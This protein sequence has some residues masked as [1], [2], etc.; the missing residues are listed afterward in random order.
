MRPY[1]QFNKGIDARRS[2][3]ALRRAEPGR[4]GRLGVRSLAARVLTAVLLAV[5]AALLALPAQAQGLTTFVSNTQ[6]VSEPRTAS[7]ITAQSFETGANPDGYTIS[8]IQLKLHSTSNPSALTSAK[9]REYNASD[10]P[11]DLVATLTNPGTLVSDSLNTFTAPAGTTLDAN[12]TY[13][14]MLNEGISSSN[15]VIFATTLS[16]EE[17]G[18]TDW[19]IGNGRLNFTTST[20]DWNTSMFSLLIEIRGTAGTLINTPATGEPAITGAAELGQTLSAATTGISDDEGTTKADAGDAG[21]AYTYQWERV[22]ADGSSNPVDIQGATDSTYTVISADV[23][24]AIRVKVNF[25]DDVGFDEGPLASNALPAGGTVTCDGV[26]CA[27]LYVQSIEGGGKG[28]AN[29]STGDACMNAAHLSEDEFNHALTD[30]RVTSVQVKSNGQLQLWMNPDIVAGS[31]TL[32]LHVGSDTFAFQNADEE[33][34]NN[35]F[36]N[37]SGLTWANG[38]AVELKLTEGPSTDAT[39]SGLALEGATGGETIDLTPVFDAGTITYTASVVNGIDAVK[40]R[41]TANDSNAM[42]VITNDDDTS[43]PD[44]AELSLNVGSNTLTLTV[45]AEDGNTTLTYTI[46]VTRAV[47]P[48]LVVSVPTLTVDEAGS[49]TFTV[50]LATQ[51]S[52]SVTVGVTSDDTGAATASPA[53]LTFTTAD[54]NTT[55]TVTVSGVD[56]SDT[57]NES[58]TVTAS[59]SGG[60]Y[61]GKTGSVSVSVTDDDTANLVLNLTSLTVDE[62]GS[63]TFTVKLATQP[64][65]SVTVGVTSDDTGAATASPASLTFTTG[66]WNTTKTVTVSGVDDSDTDNESLTVTASASGGGYAGKTGSVSVSVTDDDTANLVLNLTSLTVDEAGSGT[67]TVKLATQ[68]S[69]SVTVGVTSDDTGAA[70]ASPASLTFTMSDWDTTQTVTV[71]GV[72]DSDAAAESVMVSLSASGGGYAGKIGSVSVSVTDNDTANLV[73]TPSSLTVGETGSGTFTVKLA[74]QPSGSVTVGVS[75]DDTGAA[76]A[77]PASL[78]F[79]MSDWDTTQTVTVSGVNDSDAAAESIMVSLSASGGDYAGKIGSVSVSVTD[80]DTANLVVTPSSLTVGETG[81]GT[82]TVKL[83]TQ[84]SGSVTVGVSSDDTG[85]ATASPA[86]LT[87]TTTNW[88]TTQTVTVS[89]VDD[90]DTATESVMVSLSA[91]GGDYAGKTGSVSVSVTDNDI[92]TTTDATLSGLALEDGDGNAIPLDTE[93]ASDDYEYEVSVVNGIDAVKLSATKN[94]SNAMVAITGDTTTTT[95]DVAELSLN[96]GANTLTVTV[97]AEDGTLKTYTITV[98]R[99]DAPTQIA[100]TLVSNTD[101]TSSGSSSAVGAQSFVTGANSGGYTISEVQVRLS[102]VNGKSTSVRIRENNNSDEPGALVATL[103]NPG[104]LTDG[105]NTFT[106]PPGTMLV[107]STTYWITF[108]EDVTGSQA[109][110]AITNS[111]DETGETGWSIGDDR[112]YKLDPAL[113]TWAGPQLTSYLIAIKGPTTASTDATLSGLALVEGATGGETID[114]T[115]VFDA[116]TITYTASVANGIDAVKL[117]ATKNDGNA[118]VVIT[119]DDDTSTPDEAE[120]SLNV[121]SNTLTVTVTAEDTTELTYTITVE[122]AAIPTLV[123]NTNQT[124]I[125][126]SA[127][128]HAQIFE[129]G[130]NADGYTVSEVDV[131]LVSGSGRSTSVKIR[132]NNS[133]DRPGDLVATLTN[134]GTLTSNRLNTFTAPAGTTLAASKTYWITT[135]EGISSNRANVGR[136]GGTGETGEPGWTIGDDSLFRAAET[137]SWSTSGNSLMIEIRGTTGGYTASTDATLSGLALV[138]GDDNAIPLAF[139][140]DDYEYEVSVVNGIDSVVLSATKNDS[141]A[142]VVI[143]NDDVVNTP[144]E[145]ELDLIVGSNTLTVTVTAED[146]STELI[147][148]VTVTRLAAPPPEVMVPSDWGL[149]PSD[150]DTGDQ[151]RVLFL[152]SIKTDATSTDIADYNTFIKNRAAAGHTDIQSYSAG[153]R[154]VGCTAAVDARGNTGTNTN[155]DGA[156][157]PI[158][159]LNGNKIADDNAGFYDGDWDDEANDKNESGANGPNTGQQSNYPFTGCDHDGTKATAGASS[160]ALGASQVRLGRPNSSDTHTGPLSGT[161]LTSKSESRPMYGLSQVFEVLASTDAT[162]S[163]LAL[164]EGATGGETIDLTPVFDAETITYTASVANGIDAV[165]LTATKNDGNA[166]VVITND[167]DTSTP[168]EAELSLNVGSNT[169]TVTVTAEDTTELTYTIT[170]ERA[171]IPTL[172]SNTNQT[173]I[174]DSAHFHAQIFETGANADGYTV[175]EV[176][177]YLVSGSGRST[178]VKIR[179][180]NSSDRPGDLVATLTNPGT[181][182]SNRLNTFTAPAGTTLAASKTYWI[183]TNEG[184][185]S[186]RANVGR[187]GGTGETG[188]PGWTIGD[189]SLFR[190]A[191]TSS[192]S[193]SGNSLMIEIRGTTGGY[194]ASTDATLSGLALVDGDDNAIPLDTIFAS[195]D[196]EYEASV[197]NSV[198][199]IT[200]TPTTSD[201]N[202]SVVFLDGDDNPLTDADTVTADHEVDLGAGENTIKVKVTAEDTTVL[203]Y[204]VTVTR[205]DAPTQIAITLVSNTGESLEGFNSDNLQAQKFQT[206]ANTGG[207]TIS[208][209]RIR[210]A[211]VSGRSTSLKIRE[212]NS[213]NRPGNLVATLNNPATLTSNGLNTFTAPAGTTLA[214]STP[215]WITINEGITSSSRASYARTTSNTETGEPGWSIGNNRLWRTSNG[216]SW[217]TSTSPVLIE[218]RGTTGTTAST[219]ATLSGLALVDGDDNA[220]TLDT[221]FASD[222]YEYEAS[223]ENSVSR[224]TVTPTTSD[225][226]ASVVFL[227]GD[228]NPLTD[229]DT[230][231]ADHEVDL[232]PGE[233]T[234]KVK[235]T[236]EDTTT[237]QTYTVKVT[238]EA[239]SCDGVWC[240][241]LYVQPLGG[242]KGCANSSSGDA[243]SNAAHLS[244]D[245]F[246]HA[247][248]DYRVTSVQVKSNGQLQLWINPNIVA[249]SETLVLHVGSDTFAFQDADE[250]GV[251]SR[252]WNN[253]GFTWANDDAVELKLTEGPSIDATLSGLAL[254]G[255]TGGETIDLT[256]AFDSETI[257]YTASVVNGIDAITLSAMKNDSN[258]MVVITNDGDPN[259]PDEAELDL[260]VGANTVTVTVTAEDGTLKTYTVTVTRE[261]EETPALVSNFNQ[262]AGTVVQFSLPVA[263]RFTTGSNSGGYTLTS[264]EIKSDDSQGDTFS[265]SVCEVDGDGYPTLTCTALT[266]PGSFAAGTLVFNA[267]ASTTFSASTTYTVVAM[268]TSN[269]VNYAST[270]ADGEDTGGAVGWTLANEYDFRNTSDVWVTST[271]NKSLRVAIKGT[272]G[273]YTASTDATLSGLALEDGDGI[274]IPLAFASDDYEYEVSVVNGID[275]VKLTATKNDSNAMVA[276][277]GDTTT[278]TPDEAE[279]SLNVGSN[280]LTVTVTAEDGNTTLTYTITVTRAVPPNLVVSAS[281]LTVGEAG[282]GTFTVKLATQPSASVTVGVTSDD[283]GAAT[284]S[285]ASLTFTTG[286]WNTTKTVTVSGVD[287]SDTDNESLT[288]TASA[289]GGGYAGKTGS[290]SVSVTDDD[291]ANLVLNLT[292]LTVDEAGS[293]AFT[294]KLATQ[295]SASVTVGVT[296]DDTGAATASPASLT[297]T[298]GNWNTTK[299]VT[300]SGVDDSDT[301]NESLTVTASASGGGYA[302]KTGLG[303]RQRHGRRHGEPGVEPHEPDRG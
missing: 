107:A 195:D 191:E 215:Y 259:T 32:V 173:S 290:V 139:V 127:H 211:N 76:T 61:A 247:L 115:P 9:I 212:N 145:A 208:D 52:A 112:I 217:S 181:L 240:A 273:G 47:P 2:D 171:A 118:M 192:W 34:G 19:S 196:Y 42:V 101:R 272:T 125:G 120:L 78:T 300:V 178:S 99:A 159:W 166:M 213:S 155:T 23:G 67:F 158:Y 286:N 219:D 291:T 262:A 114:L 56:D 81:S 1:G 268:A 237:T 279:L 297:F 63:G 207:Y 175:S 133:S 113:L 277:T 180:N 100:I 269:V 144:D 246:N 267:P 64:S 110:V 230:V 250:E 27:T 243:C 138:D 201:A 200:V 85:A 84:P 7:L 303:E 40:L 241:T 143:T 284:A 254:E 134:P 50:K 264:V 43:T 244:E 229:A 60:G 20:G 169:L 214:A 282:S 5:F 109:N 177:V 174:G 147:Y 51:P 104:I 188:E 301:D 255:A 183:T 288:V 141:N 257:T 242:S 73:V 93:F 80:N 190:A 10:E 36:W 189:D 106:A 69:A 263:Q 6:H 266:A 210:T 170:V 149:I 126:D 26:W 233:N 157:V 161:S 197:E 94:D 15:T 227:D 199:R 123:S 253:S 86:S 75:S 222:D 287:D 130:A 12:T 116:E 119:N 140:S 249:G 128:F 136:V 202:A 21:Y 281:S 79:T 28:C 152:S 252:F 167:G 25:T 168:D 235:V 39:L 150:L 13:F 203:T 234:I 48:N 11:G 18:E 185:S 37:N 285:P 245:E 156:G 70:T 265:V 131:Y 24:R 142:M 260:V 137:S 228:D 225:A 71:S 105:L 22:D 248:T 194:T 92:T 209:V 182:T 77:S 232:G 226:N 89:G 59:A 206:G 111:D 121:G 292:S 55:K 153:F 205:A 108:N 216:G 160:R 179:E 17:T 261:Q 3:T 275:A 49:G 68:P 163:G 296:S 98:T 65:A 148:T 72:N 91:S 14:I 124:S 16:D 280:T 298:T 289:S 162:L 132:E 31:E 302:G 223:V 8:N 35:R 293:G 46:T 30:Y 176:D 172:V 193:T 271:S 184:I 218:I 62:A 87:F 256:P 239:A 154:A 236:A 38:N 278:S 96:V 97:T 83:A 204:T 4:P 220:I 221:I 251:N 88:D 58:L 33:L 135:N 276:I 231:T 270:S 151:F 299:T 258:A 41:A 165:K 102:N 29:S 274:A 295:P 44:E 95:P 129:T 187:V 53:S 74:T 294:V 57:D 90:S 164:V 117:T 198:S 103:T 224:I 146:G 122:R 66:N 186:N 238:Q 45:T 82:F 283:T 54:W